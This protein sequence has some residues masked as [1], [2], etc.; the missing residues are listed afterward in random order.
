MS[1]SL[2]VTWKKKAR[3]QNNNKG[4]ILEKNSCIKLCLDKKLCVE[5]VECSSFK[6]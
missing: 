5:G 4:T 1:Q 2:C 3:K 6:G